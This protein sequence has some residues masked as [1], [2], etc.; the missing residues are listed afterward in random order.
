MNK[1]ASHTKERDRIETAAQFINS[2]A[3]HIFL[4]GK[5][6]TGKTTFLKNLAK[7]THKQLA[8]VAPTGIAALNAGGVTIHSQF[9][10]PFGMFIPD[11]NVSEDFN[12]GVNFYSSNML[13]RKHPLNSS[14]K[15]VLRSIDLLVIDEVSMLRADLLD[16]IDY[17][18]KAAR[19]NFYQSFGGVQL[20]LIGDLY[21]LPPVVK[22]E[23]ELLMRNHYSS[24]WFFESKALQKDGFVYIEFDKIFRQH[25]DAFIDLLNNLRNN[26]ATQDD[27]DTLNKSYKTTEEIESIKEVITLTTHNYKADEIN[28]RSLKNLSTPLHTMHAT[29]EGDFPD[30]MHPVQ[31]HLELKVGA[32]VMFTKNDS[33]SKM[34]FNGKL[35]TVKKIVGEEVEVEMGG[36]HELFE[37]RKEVWENKRY[38]LNA[39]TQDIED[40]IIGTFEQYP[41]KL[42]WAI[43]V[44]KSQGLTFDRAIIDVGQAFADG[45]VYVALSRLRSL[46]GLILRT[47]VQPSV[48]STDSDIVTFTNKNSR[49]EELPALIKVRQREYILQLID[50]TFNFEILEKELNYIMR[51][52]ADEA[53]LLEESMKP[54]PEQIRNSLLNEKVNTEKFRRQLN[55]HLQSNDHVQLLG[56]IKAGSEY[57]KK[58]LL[59]QIGFLLQHKEEMSL[60]KRVK[61]YVTSL[62]DVDTMFAKKLEE[63][64]KVLYLTEAIFE[65]RDHFDFTHLAYQRKEERENMLIEIKSKVDALPGKKKPKKKKRDRS[66]KKDERSTYDITFD[67]FKS[68]MGVA[69]IAKERG[70]TTG[71]IDGHLARG[72]GAHVIDIFAFV[73]K[74]DVELITSAIMEMPE[75]F[76]SK[77]L[78][79]KLHGKYSY[80]QLRAVMVFLKE[81]ASR[82]SN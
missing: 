40:E 2:T 31:Q 32:Q 65:D 27:I 46:D 1:E 10:L 29:I 7:R 38:T 15:Q 22:R 59:Q 69:D 42:A 68:G 9:L 39:T 51:N 75:E 36:T 58:F 61:G 26:V 25:D 20:L 13:A 18:M 21:Q 79:D 37:L 74:D 5:A 56:R 3:S 57:Y 19:G 44:H 47:K 80:G 35:A 66:T 64:D 52:H 33:E 53:A 23:E 48:I 43:T 50:R 72:V 67:L 17:R 73:P 41:I 8:I 81:H 78:Y 49:P 55:D 6:G 45:Q 62:S 24:A 11:R 71:T 76:S 34:Y 12:S 60:R 77:E 70:L 63:I 54:V 28:Q 16:A 4:T 14:R 30:S 82:E